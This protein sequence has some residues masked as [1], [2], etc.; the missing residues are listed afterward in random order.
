MENIYDIA[1]WFLHKESM[2]NKKLQKMCYYAQAWYAALYDNIL[3]D[4]RVEAWV[5][6]PVIPK[7]YKKYKSYGWDLIPKFNN[8][9]DFCEEVLELLE[10]VYAT[11]CDLTGY[12]L[13]LLTHSEAPWINARKGLSRFTPSNNLISHKDMHD[14]YLKVYEDE[15]ND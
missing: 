10:S 12:E 1:N 8:E 5:H 4:E 2:T 11:Y 9:I 6:G 14:F 3:F 13:E 15:Q 7:L